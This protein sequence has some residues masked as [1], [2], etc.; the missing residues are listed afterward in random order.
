MRI[1]NE[2]TR[3]FILRFDF[4]SFINFCELNCDAPVS[5]LK[6]VATMLNSV[7]QSALEIARV[8]LER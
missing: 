1:F 2:V 5:V 8:Y 3:Y 4:R 6:L 7:C